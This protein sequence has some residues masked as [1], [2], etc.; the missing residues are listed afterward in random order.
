MV[1]I[2]EV[3]MKTTKVELS[4]LTLDYDIYPRTMV[5][6]T[7]VRMMQDA[8]DAGEK[9]PPI[10]VDAASGRIVDGFHRYTR[11]HK[12]GED[13]IVAVLEDFEDEAAIFEA[14]VRAN[15]THGAPYT[16]FERAKIVK[17][18]ADFGLTVERISSSLCITIER[19][20]EIQSGFVGVGHTSGPVKETVAHLR[21]GRITKEQAEA[22]KKLGGMPQRFY[23]EQLLI[24]VE[25]D[26]VNIHDEGMMAKLARLNESLTD[27]LRRVSKKVRA[28]A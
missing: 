1:F 11:A 17:Q 9:L 10:L 25:N 19:L 21:G 4:K 2:N 14:A 12:N 24:L 23:V 28:R 15:A 18:A 6:D 3:P 22:A 13:T 7:H 27:L 8:V 16:P 20:T 5:S 26:L